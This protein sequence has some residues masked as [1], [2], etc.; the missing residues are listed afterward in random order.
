VTDPDE[1]EW[2]LFKLLRSYSLPNLYTTPLEN[3][4]ATSPIEVT[5]PPIEEARPVVTFED[6]ENE[7]Q[8]N[9]STLH[10]MIS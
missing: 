9:S 6:E 3:L 8:V 10:T 2:N 4:I 7:D 1:E 5:E